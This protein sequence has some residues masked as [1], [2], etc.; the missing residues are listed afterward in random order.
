MRIPRLLGVVLTIVASGLLLAAPTGAQP[1]FRLAGY[2]ADNA[3]VLTDSGR[4]AVT[5]AVDQLYAD[6]R[7]RLWVVYV[8]NFSGQSAEQWA[9]R[10]YTTSELGENDA[11]LAVSVAGRAYAFLVPATMR[12]VS[13]SQV[14]DLRHTH[15]EP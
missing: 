6:R 8:D 15:I 2:V 14:E 9:K 4:T 12:N 5:S 1:P 7:I 11:I 3:G 10:T 13:Q